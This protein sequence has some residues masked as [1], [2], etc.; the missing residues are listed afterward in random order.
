MNSEVVKLPQRL[1]RRAQITH[2]KLWLLPGRE[3]C[4]FVVLVVKDEFRIRLFSPTLW[5]LVDFFRESAYGDRNLD[6]P[7]IEEAAG[8]KIMSRV[9]VETRRRDRGVRQPVK[10]DVVENIVR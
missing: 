2:E 9:P 3:V 6:A 10:R 5:R 8:R 1:E 4:A 7:H